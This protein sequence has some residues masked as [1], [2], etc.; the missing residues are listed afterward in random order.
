M[1]RINDDCLGR[2]LADLNKDS[3]ERL[4][5]SWTENG[6]KKP[7]GHGLVTMLR[8]LLAFGATELED[9][10]CVRLSVVLRNMRFRPAKPRNE[11]M[12]EEQAVA[13]IRKSNEIGR[14]S[15]ALAQALQ[16]NC[17]LHQK[18]VIGEW[19]PLDDPEDSKIVVGTEKWVRGIQWS[20]IDDNLIL[21]H[22]TSSDRKKIEINLRD[23]PMVMAELDKIGERPKDGAIIIDEDTGKPY[24]AWKFR[25][26]WRRFATFVGVPKGV[27]NM[28]SRSG[29]KSKK[30]RATEASVALH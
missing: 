25:R 6:K 30:A 4:Y 22:I 10:E 13:I 21:R 16:F 23:A 27:W 20:D 11:P 26:L 24:P 29:G 9:S 2:R 3:I 12:T 28:D 18:D 14:R 17:G 15:I 19:V 8:M 7:M 5:G 1:D